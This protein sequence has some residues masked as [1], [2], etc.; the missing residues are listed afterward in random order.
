MHLEITNTKAE[1]L[2]WQRQDGLLEIPGG[3]VDWL[4]SANRPESYEEAALREA[5]EELNLLANWQA[6]A[7][8][9]RARLHRHLHRIAPLIINQ[10]P[11]VRGFNNEWVAVYTLM[12]QDPWGDLC[13]FV[14]SEEGHTAPRWLTLEAVKQ[15]SMQHPMGIN[16]ALRLFLGRRGILIPLRP[17]R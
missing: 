2:V 8:E 3:H 7:D 14:L 6:S 11:R 15:E 13:Q 5:T 17:R 10:L 16:A 1:Y 4:S 12:W 9:V